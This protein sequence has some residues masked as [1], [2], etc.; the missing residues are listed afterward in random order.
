[1][2]REELE[3]ELQKVRQ[4]MSAVPSSGEAGSSVED[5]R[6]DLTESF[7]YAWIQ[8]FVTSYQFQCCKVNICLN[9][10]C[11]H[12]RDVHNE[13]ELDEQQGNNH[14]SI[15]LPDKR[16]TKISRSKN[17]LDMHCTQQPLSNEDPRV[18]HFMEKLKRMQAAIRE[19]RNY[20]NPSR[21]FIWVNSLG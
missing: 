3:V 13:N 14:Q 2:Q 18:Q 11:R 21:D 8:I 9:F 7:T 6:I 12:S 20:K 4:Q 15:E 19:A 17:E 16:V 5:K 10:S 1:M